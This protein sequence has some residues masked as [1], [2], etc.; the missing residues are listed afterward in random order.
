MPRLRL[1]LAYVGTNYNGW[2]RQIQNGVELPT[3]QGLVEKEISHICNTK[4]HLQGSGRTDSGV[5][6]DCQ[7]AHCDIPEDKTKLNWQ[8]ALNTAL[9]PDIRIRNFALVSD[10][11]HALFDVEKKA[12]TY[13]LWLNRDFVPPKLY[14]FT[15]VCGELDLKAVDAAIPYLQGEHDFSFVQ[16][17]GTELHSTVR[18][19]YE[20]KRSNFEE[21]IKNDPNNFELKITF[22]ANGFLKQ[23]VRNLIGLLV[24]CGKGKI[25]AQNIP[26]LINGKDRKKSPPTAPPQGLTMSQIWYNNAE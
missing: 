11:F 5:H 16:N 8:L 1:T 4:I 12:Y 26:D 25:A 13:S 7:V 22:I 6:A 20:I 23:M 3:V 14:P 10:T 17:Q 18:T 21:Q 24:A 19:L 9:P 2:Q 15:W